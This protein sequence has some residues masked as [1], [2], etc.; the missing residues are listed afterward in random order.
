MKAFQVS[1]LAFTAL[2]ACVSGCSR[3]YSF[4]GVVVDGNGVGIADANIVLFPSD[5]KRSE[6]NDEQSN[7][8]TKS[9]G[10]FEATWCCDTGVKFFTMITSKPGYHGD[11]RLV[12][13]DE[14][15]VRVLLSMEPLKT[16]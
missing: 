7:G 12:R 8:K 6:H 2:F 10:T 5:W 3:A 14:K 11:V 15:N 1:L 4:T 9:D 13:A 16:E